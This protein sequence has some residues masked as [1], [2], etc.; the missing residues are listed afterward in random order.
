MS[1]T[2]FR[3]VRVFIDLIWVGGLPRDIP[4]LALTEGG[5]DSAHLWYMWETTI[6]EES[7]R[8]SVF[9]SGYP[10]SRSRREIRAAQG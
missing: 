5:N 7:S 10:R 6:L 9:A 1:I 4:Y 3:R 8:I 2:E